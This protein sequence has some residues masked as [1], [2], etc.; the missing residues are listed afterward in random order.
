VKAE[1]KKIPLLIP[2]PE[3]TTDNAAMI[4]AAAAYKFRRD[5]ITT[6]KRL[7]VDASLQLK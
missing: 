2:K 5:E 7:K 6:Y 4:A 1:L 3:Y